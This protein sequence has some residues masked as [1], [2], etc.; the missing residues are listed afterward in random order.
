MFQTKSNVSYALLF[1]EL[2][3]EMKNKKITLWEKLYVTCEM[4]AHESPFYSL[5]IQVDIIA[6]ANDFGY[7][8]VAIWVRMTLSAK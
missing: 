7:Q 3:S 6:F 1:I 4:I 2:Q 5:S 8:I